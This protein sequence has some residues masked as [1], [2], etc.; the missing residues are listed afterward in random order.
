MLALALERLPRLPGAEPR[1][2][3]EDQPYDADGRQAYGERRVR[4]FADRAG[5]RIR[6]IKSRLVLRP[7][8]PDAVTLRR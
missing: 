6:K 3:L 1:P 8:G 4:P 7:P 2:A 5:Y